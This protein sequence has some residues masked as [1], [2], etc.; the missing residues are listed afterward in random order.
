MRLP[1]EEALQKVLTGEITDA[2]SIA[3]LLRTRVWL[4]LEK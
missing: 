4:E 3:G 2:I 1:F